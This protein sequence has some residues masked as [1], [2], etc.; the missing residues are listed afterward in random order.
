MLSLVMIVKNES[1]RIRETLESVK[2]G[3]DSWTIVDTGSTDGTQEIIR[4]VMAG[5]PGHLHAAPFVDFATT[6]NLAFSLAPRDHWRLVLSGDAIVHNAAA[7]RG[8]TSSHSA[9]YIRSRMGGIEY[10]TARLTKRPW[11]Y[12][13]AVHEHP[14]GPGPV[15]PRVPGVYVEH[16]AQ[17]GSKT[18]VWEHHLHL[19]AAAP[20]TP[21]NMFYRAQ[22]LDCLGRYNEA[23]SVYLERA[24]AGG[25]DEE[26]FVAMLRAGQCFE[27]LDL[28]HEALCCYESATRR[29]PMRAPEARYKAARMH[30]ATQDWESVYRELEGAASWTDPIDAR[31]FVDRSVYH[32][33]GADLL[34]VAARMTGRF[35][36]AEDVT[37]GLRGA[38]A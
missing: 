5:M 3:I 21:R 22:T 8:F 1:H 25:W 23:A 13:G 27:R 10:D 15:G 7:L 19:F 12:K 32:W 4:D 14:V 36:E 37:R 34:A 29:C 20:K 2:P 31:L 38:A 17:A 16:L 26:E 11:H 30:E 35:K 6:R 9:H 28:R 18:S 24:A 33:R